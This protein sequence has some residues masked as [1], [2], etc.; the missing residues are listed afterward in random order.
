MRW[1][2]CRCRPGSSREG[3]GVIADLA[4]ADLGS[5]DILVTTFTDPSWTPTF[6][7]IA[8]LVTEVGDR[9]PMGR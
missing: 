1:S 5:G 6:V 9:L 7:T 2:V 8:G 3:R 4:E